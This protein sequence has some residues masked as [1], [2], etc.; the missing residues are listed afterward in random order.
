MMNAPH[1]TEPENQEKYTV[2][3]SQGILSNFEPPSFLIDGW[4][5][6]DSHGVLYAASQAFKSFVAIDIGH[7]IASGRSFCGNEIDKQGPVVFIIGEGYRGFSKRLYACQKRNGET[8]NIHLINAQPNISSG[9][10]M[11]R[12]KN[13]ITEI[14][15]ALIVVDTFS[16]LALGVNENDNSDVAKT[17]ALVRNTAREV[18]SSSL[19]I[20]HLGKDSTQGA[21]G[22]SAFHN[23]ADFTMELNRQGESLNTILSAKKMKDGE[24]PNP[25]ELSLMEINIG[26]EDKRGKPYTSLAVDGY[27]TLNAKPSKSATKGDRYSEGIKRAMNNLG[28]EHGPN[29][30]SH[31][32]KQVPAFTRSQIKSKMFE[33]GDIEF[34]ENT[35]KPSG[36]DEQAFK[37]AVTKLK[38]TGDLLEKKNH[39]WFA[40]HNDAL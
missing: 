12:V 18:N 31:Q 6:E 23:N 32:G 20:H 14:Q 37:R 34:E 30:N 33:L 5:E 2:L 25:I 40:H 9:I 13:S 8:D 17:L 36:K 7:C 28:I 22:A 16:S 24:P 10:D 35:N 29:F 21:R 19:L 15:P 38:Q 27:K 3:N 1:W 39:L 4:I 11:Q 26:G